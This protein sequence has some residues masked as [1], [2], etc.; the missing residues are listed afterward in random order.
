MWE[1]LGTSCLSKTI[2]ITI[3]AI[4]DQELNETIQ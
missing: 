2:K 4:L 3:P 1:I